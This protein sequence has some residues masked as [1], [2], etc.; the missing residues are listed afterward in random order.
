M[1]RGLKVFNLGTTAVDVRTY[2][3]HALLHVLRGADSGNLNPVIEHSDT[4]TGG[5]TDSGAVAFPA[6][7]DLL[8]AEAVAEIDMDKFKRYIRYGTSS[9]GDVATVVAQ[10]IRT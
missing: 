5:W 4:G 1:L 10:S 7:T 9:V 3:G 2:S 8:A 6:G